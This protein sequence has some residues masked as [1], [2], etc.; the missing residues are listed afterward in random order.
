MA[1]RDV[2]FVPD[3]AQP[4]DDLAF[5]DRD[6]LVQRLFMEIVNAGNGVREGRQGIHTKVA[7]S[8]Y[9]GVG[10]SALLARVLRMLRD[11]PPGTAPMRDKERWLI[12]YFSGKNYSS[13]DALSDELPRLVREA[14]PSLLDSGP[15]ADLVRDLAED[16]QKPAAQVSELRWFH[17]LF[18]RTE[19]KLFARVKDAVEA[20]GIALAYV[21][22]WRGGQW[23]RGLEAN[24][25]SERELT[26]RSN[27]RTAAEFKAELEA[28]TTVVGGGTAAAGLDIAADI[29]AKNANKFGFSES[30]EKTSRVNAE[31]LVDALNHLFATLRQANIPTI[32][33]LDDLDDFAS[34]S[35]A[36]YSGRAR[37]LS[38]VL[39]ELYR[40]RPSVLLLG[41]RQEYK[42][43][44]INRHFNVMNVPPMLPDEAREILQAWASHRAR[45]LSTE[46]LIA[47][48]ALANKLLSPFGA[49]ERAI[50]ASQFL[51]IVSTLYN[52]GRSDD[53]EV[54]DLLDSF[55]SDE[56]SAAEGRA[57]REVSRLLRDED[58]ASCLSGGEIDPSSTMALSET[59]RRQL[60]NA[61]LLRPA[62]AGDPENV[63]IV[64]D[65]LV[66]WLRRAT[67]PR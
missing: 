4:T 20:V 41:L 27:A 26:L 31:V 61:N 24:R 63:H 64:L 6:Q 65:P 44:E 34:G 52:R 43:H 28:L 25:S 42:D 58:Q 36:S 10:K 47:L 29:L 56:F 55:I 67:R 23:K 66:A 14:E 51:K 33:V 60:E 57:L 22:A 62:L 9:M 2:L 32:L 30:V 19:G 50:V 54:I 11:P 45:P 21:S 48:K 59:E 49:S 39:A 40:L 13:F 35:G 18:Q 16:V 1:K 3:S 12:L 53:E 38:A 7:V 37:I 8:G 46:S 15:F 5:A 17:H